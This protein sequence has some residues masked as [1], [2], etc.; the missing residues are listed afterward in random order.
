MNKKRTSALVSVGVNPDPDNPLTCT[1][2]GACDDPTCTAEAC[3]DIACKNGAWTVLL[4]DG[5]YEGDAFCSEHWPTV[6][7]LLG[8]PIDLLTGE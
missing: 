3:S 8:F 4:F 2:N 5:Q 6:A 7:R 1:G